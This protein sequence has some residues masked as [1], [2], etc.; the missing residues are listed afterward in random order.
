MHMAHPFLD[1]RIKIMI[2]FN[3]HWGGEV[4]CIILC[5]RP[6]LVPTSVSGVPA[7][8]QEYSWELDIACREHADIGPCVQG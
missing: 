3:T 7:H 5:L 2:D 6:F 8:Q 1:F 4:L